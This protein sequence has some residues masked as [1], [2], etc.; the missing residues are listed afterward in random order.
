MNS[1]KRGLGVGVGRL[2]GLCLA[3]GG[4]ASSAGADVG[5]GGWLLNEEDGSKAQVQEVLEGAD[6]M[7]KPT[8]QAP[9]N[10]T[11]APY[12]GP[13]S[14]GEGYPKLDI[15]KTP[16]KYD[17]QYFFGLSRGVFQEDVPGAV[18]GVSLLGTVPLDLVGVPFATVAGL[19]GR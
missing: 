16:W 2:L 10:E 7:L 17:G 13:A 1:T 14:E 9:L 11:E 5:S 4:L 6:E 15:P 19:F 8:A 3:L 18:K 12:V